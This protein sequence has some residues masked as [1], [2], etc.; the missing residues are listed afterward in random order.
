MTRVVITPRKSENI[1]GMMVAKE[2]ALRKK[3]SG[4]LHRSGPKK[5]GRD[6]WI[7]KSYKGWV[8]FQRGPGGVVVALVQSKSPNSETQI[9]ESFVG[10]LNRH[11][12]GAI[13]AISLSY[14]AE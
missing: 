9:L 12:R 11:F 7:H 14:E 2:L 1:Y 4:T 5:P 8:G 10:F 13:S 6:K 3:K